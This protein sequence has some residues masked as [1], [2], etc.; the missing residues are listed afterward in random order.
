MNRSELIE[1]LMSLFDSASSIVEAK[2]HD[3]T[4]GNDDAFYNFRFSER[5]TGVSVPRGILI[6]V[7]DKLARLKTLIN[8]EN[9]AVKEESVEDTILDTINYLAIL[10][11]YLHAE[12][13][14]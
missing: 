6:R 12:R 7:S 9:P 4:G 11:A 10:H 2:N 1:H 8:G 3:Y 5:V 13:N 14:K